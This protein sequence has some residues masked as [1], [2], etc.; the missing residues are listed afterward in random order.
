MVAGEGVCGEIADEKGGENIE[1]EDGQNGTAA[2]MRDHDA[3]RSPKAVK[4]ALNF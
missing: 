2:T 3:P 4:A 1:T